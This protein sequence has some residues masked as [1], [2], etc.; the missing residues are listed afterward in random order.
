MSHPSTNPLG[1]GPLAGIRIL[2]LGQMIAGPFCG[3]LLG[4][5]GAEVIKV[6]RPGVGDVMR[7]WGQVKPNGRSLWWPVI[8]RNKKSITIDLRTPLGQATV[9]D[10]VAHCDVIIENFRPGRMESWGLGYDTLSSINPT[11]VMVRISGFG[12]SGPYA[13]R[14]GFGVIGEAMGGLRYIVGVPDQPPTRVGIAIGDALAGTLGAFAA[15]VAVLESRRSGKGQMID[16]AIYEAVLAFME[17]LVPEYEIG[18]HIRERTGA[19]LPGVAPSNIYPTADNRPTLIAANQDSVFARLAE[20]MGQPELASDPRF[21]SHTSRG[22]NQETLDALV[23]EWTRSQPVDELLDALA[24]GGV[25]AG[26]IYR[27][28]E[29]LDDP[30]Y[31][32]REAIVRVPDEDFGSIPMQGVFPKLSRTPGSVRWAGP[33]LGEHNEEVLGG[34]L[35]LDSDAIAALE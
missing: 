10:L 14:A 15:L 11:L 26:R 20:L 28:P 8:S 25:P 5:F 18:G 34:L 31:A 4:D 17:S 22:E 35:G 13:K 16:M 3:Q 1:E 32:A 19:T 2:E 9:K 12:Q 29:M 21:D 24:E 6:E 30:Q 23:A 33:D 27:A 7:E